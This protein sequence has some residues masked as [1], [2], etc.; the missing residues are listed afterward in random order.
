MKKAILSPFAICC[1]FCLFVCLFV[2]LFGYRHAAFSER[3][4]RSDQRRTENTLSHNRQSQLESEYVT[5]FK[6]GARVDAVDIMTTRAARFRTSRST[7]MDY[8]KCC[9]SACFIFEVHVVC[10][11]TCIH[12]LCFH[13]IW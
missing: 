13:T 10:C 12:F 4:V 8:L 11:Y 9:R 7:P 5:D 6:D 1:C 3:K 2:L